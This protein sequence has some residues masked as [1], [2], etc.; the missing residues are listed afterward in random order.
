MLKFQ[1]LWMIETYWTL[2]VSWAAS[3]EITFF[4]LAVCLS[5]CLP[6]TKFSQDWIISFFDIVH[7][8]S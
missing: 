4:R 3:Y 6:V 1:A 7:D 8:D 5:V 2:A